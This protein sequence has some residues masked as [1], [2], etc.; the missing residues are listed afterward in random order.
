MRIGL[1]KPQV[2]AILPP[3]LQFH[4]ILVNLYDME[5]E[6]VKCNLINDL[7][8]QSVQIIKCEIN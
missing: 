8:F 7:I 5:R 6:I 1:I 4:N 3:I 2:N